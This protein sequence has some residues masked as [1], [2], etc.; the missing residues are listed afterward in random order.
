MVIKT[1]CYIFE[2]NLNLFIMNYK[3]FL[4]G[5]CAETS[6][7]EE[8]RLS[9]QVPSFNPVVEDWTEDY[10]EIERQE[11]DYKC[12]IHLY[13]ITSAMK[14]VFSIAEAVQSSLTKGKITILHIIPKG[15]NT[16]ELKSLNAVVDM[17]QRN[18][19]IAYIDN[20]LMRTARIINFSF[21]H[22]FNIS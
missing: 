4:G 9:L 2:V 10:Q 11:K 3:V 13:V 8:L 12:N 14:G 5:T 18:G 7:R 17:I 15:F 22:S 19:G 6:W 16:H 21:S 1:Q 20:E